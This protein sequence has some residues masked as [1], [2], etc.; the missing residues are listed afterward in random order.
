MEPSLPP[1]CPSDHSFWGTKAASP[2]SFSAGLRLALGGRTLAV[3]LFGVFCGF[4]P[5][6]S[7]TDPATA[8]TACSPCTPHVTHS[9]C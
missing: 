2:M 5:R 6:P 4:R 8:G 7:S 1:T 9:V 3:A